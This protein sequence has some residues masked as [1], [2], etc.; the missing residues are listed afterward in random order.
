MLAMYMVTVVFMGGASSFIVDERNSANERHSD[1]KPQD[2]TYEEPCV[3]K[4]AFWIV[5]LLFVF[6]YVK[7]NGCLNGCLNARFDV[8]GFSV[9]LLR[10]VLCF[11]V[12]TLWHGAVFLFHMDI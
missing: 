7:T 3:P 9:R 5:W 6:Y 4:Q 11:V 10:C 2:M 1:S 12:K 8:P